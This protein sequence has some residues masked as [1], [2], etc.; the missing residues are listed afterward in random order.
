[1]SESSIARLKKDD[2][3]QSFSSLGYF[4]A[5]IGYNLR[6]PL[7]SSL[8]VRRALGMAIDIDQII[9]Y[10]LYEEGERVTGPY[11]KMTD[12]YDHEVES[13]PYNPDD[14][15]KILNDKQF[16]SIFPDYIYFDHKKGLRETVKYYRSTILKNFGVSN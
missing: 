6:N 11:P 3:Y 12:W 4:Y 13:L 16:R 15:I 7:F 9:K 14:A 2:N 10:V 5:Y 8:K 1:M